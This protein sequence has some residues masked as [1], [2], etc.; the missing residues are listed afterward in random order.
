MKEFELE[1]D[2]WFSEMYKIRET[3]IPT[4]FNDFPMSGLMRT[5]SRSESENSFF[6][7]FMN[8]GATL[9][10]FMMCYETA[11]E[12][13]GSRLDFLDHLS[14]SK[15]GAYLTPMAIEQHASKIYTRT[16]F[17]LVQKEISLAIFKC[18]QN[19]VVEG[20][21]GTEVYTIK[22]AREFKKT[23]E[24][25]V[26]K[27]S[28]DKFQVEDDQGIVTV[29]PYSTVEETENA[30]RIASEADT[31]KKVYNYKVC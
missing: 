12:R 23:T 3:W 2:K 27:T 21:D 6:D 9:V 18:S 5:T 16:I 30:L 31:V 8:S 19:N 20:E 10:Q 26:K 4:F 24:K 22:E 28:K 14:H 15:R 11:I 7:L 29:D 1:D 13:Q 17:L 25:V